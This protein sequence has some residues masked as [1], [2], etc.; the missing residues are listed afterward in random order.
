MIKAIGNIY[1]G[2]VQDEKMGESFVKLPRT[3][4]KEE[5]Q[6]KCNSSFSKLIWPVLNNYT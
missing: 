1:F 3:L 6:M 5:G 2:I 4:C